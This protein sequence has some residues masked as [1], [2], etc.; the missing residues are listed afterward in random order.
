MIVAPNKPPGARPLQKALQSDAAAAQKSVQQQQA[1]PAEPAEAI[2]LKDLLKALVRGSLHCDCR[3]SSPA[4]R[5]VH[6]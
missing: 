3:S 6:H 4:C 1:P 5:A 2:V